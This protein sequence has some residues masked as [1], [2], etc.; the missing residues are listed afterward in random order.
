MEYVNDISLKSRGG[1]VH[2][3]ND[4]IPMMQSTSLY[5]PGIQSTLVTFLLSDVCEGKIIISTM[6]TII[7]GNI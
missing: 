2:V 3:K 4:C 5:L 1:L 7:V 6:D